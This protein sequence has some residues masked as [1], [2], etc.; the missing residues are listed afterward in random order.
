MDARVA[1]FAAATAKA[2]FSEL[3]A[4]AE[5]GE[6]ITIKRHGKAVAKLSP[7]SVAV[8]S[9]LTLE[10]RLKV[11]E[12]WFAYR[13]AHNIKLLPGETVKDLIEDGRRF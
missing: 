11:W 1:E 10:Q 13:D 8:K 5:A 4:R 12:D 2:R 3:L 6:E 9:E 7:A